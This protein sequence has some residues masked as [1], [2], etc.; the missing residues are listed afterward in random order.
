MK[1]FAEHWFIVAGGVV[2]LVIVIILAVF[3]VTGAIGFPWSI[4]ADGLTWFNGLGAL[5]CWITIAAVATYKS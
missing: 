1:N 2:A 4:I 5:F 3:V